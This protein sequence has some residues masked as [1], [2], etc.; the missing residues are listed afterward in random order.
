MKKLILAFAI[1]ST[2]ICF[3]QA[4][5][6]TGQLTIG[7]ANNIGNT[8]NYIKV[9][10]VD[11]ELTGGLINGVATRTDAITV[12]VSVWKSKSS[13]TNGKPALQAFETPITN[14]IKTIYTI[15]PAT[16]ATSPS[17]NLNSL[18]GHTLRDKEMYWVLTQVLN[19]IIVDNPAFTG[20]IVDVNL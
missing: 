4:I 11:A 19:L 20:T 7:D 10:I 5:A 12:F 14:E 2:S 16:I 8:T 1:L 15:S 17:A 9:K 3:S 6:L 13:Y 18:S